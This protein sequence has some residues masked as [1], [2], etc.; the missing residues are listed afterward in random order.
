MRRLRTL[1]H[2]VPVGIDVTE[3]IAA[4]RMTDGEV[5]VAEEVLA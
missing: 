2:L 5:R 1:H 4:I 3:E